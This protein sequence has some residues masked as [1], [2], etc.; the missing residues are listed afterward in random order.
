MKRLD[1]LLGTGQDAGLRNT[2][3][4]LIRCLHRR[5]KR[6]GRTRRPTAEVGRLSIVDDSARYEVYVII[7]VAPACR[8]Q[9]RKCRGK[10]SNPCGISVSCVGLSGTELV[11]LAF[12]L[13]KRTAMISNN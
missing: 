1:Y 11:T 13:W 5:G 7:F 6:F 10:V 8:L 2:E 3:F 4:A 12:Y 9:L